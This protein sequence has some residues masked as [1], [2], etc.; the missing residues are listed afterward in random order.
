MAA[1]LG[2]S[3]CTVSKILNRSFDGFSYSPLTIEKVEKLAKRRRYVPNSHARSLR[4][5][6]NMTIGLVVPSGMPFFT[7]SLVELV[8]AA[9]RKQ[10]YET[11]VGHSTSQPELEEHLIRNMLGRGLDGL[12]WIPFAGEL[13]PRGLQIPAKF[14]LVLLDRPNRS[15]R[16]PTVLTDNRAASRDLAAGIAVAGQDSVTVFTSDC[17]DESIAEREQGIR[18][19]FKNR[20]QRI[21]VPNETA[22]A[23]HAASELL[24]EKR[25]DSLI[26]L[27]QCLAIGVLQ[28]IRDQNLQIGTDIGFACF[29]DLPFCEIWNPGICRIQQNLDLIC[30]EAVRL[31]IEKIHNPSARQPHEVRVPARLVWGNSAVSSPVSKKNS[32]KPGKLRNFD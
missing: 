20:V 27:T 19:V 15:T 22:A 10:G 30:E 29:D 17:S 13:N 16:F 2:L 31:L 1:E 11:I 12:L 5:N 3:I 9:L 8:V 14:P 26:C 21:A 6:R 18:D 7:G 25:V 23:L 28:A 32:S 4:T 24:N